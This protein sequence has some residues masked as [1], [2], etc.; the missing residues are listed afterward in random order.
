MRVGWI[1]VGAI[2]R[3][4][5]DRVIA[6]GYS[7]TVFDRD[8]ERIPTHT[9]KA[10]TPLDVAQASDAVI[11]ALPDGNVVREV[12]FGPEGCAEGMR[13]KYLIDTSS[14]D[15]RLTVELASRL[16]RETGG[17]WVDAPIS[18]GAAAAA[19][20]QLT[21]FVGGTAAAVDIVD[22]LIASFANRR[23]HLGDSGQGQWAKLFN[24][25]IVCGTIALWSEAM[26]LARAGGLDPSQL[27]DALAGS[28]AESRVREAFGPQI[29]TGTYT[30]SAN[31]EKDIAMVLAHLGDE[32]E[33]SALLKNAA[34]ILSGMKQRR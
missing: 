17:Q 14:I 15:P 2:G 33:K 18:G 5:L 29:A 6:A 25:A 12:V 32:N 3:P 30:P 13:R 31:L 24:Q 8:P 28:G 1:G 9:G 21:A 34:R 23:T 19:K 22:P 10:R 4:M 11:L 7:V 27:V 16:T 26:T 20:G